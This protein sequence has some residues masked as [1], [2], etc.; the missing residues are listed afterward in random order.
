MMLVQ[1][2]AAERLDKILQYL[3]RV[4]LNLAAAWAEHLIL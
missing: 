3:L 1:V 4:R 2:I